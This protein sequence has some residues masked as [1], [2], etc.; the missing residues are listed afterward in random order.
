MISSAICK[1]SGLSLTPYY[2][3]FLFLW[4]YICYSFERSHVIFTSLFQRRMMD[5]FDQ[6]QE[7]IWE[8]EDTSSRQ[9]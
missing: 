8:D 4:L 6:R 7:R 2:F 9:R 1:F 3:V 5:L